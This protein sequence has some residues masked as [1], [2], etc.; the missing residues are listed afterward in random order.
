ARLRLA[1]RSLRSLAGSAQDGPRSATIS[2][3][4]LA[5]GSLRARF[6]RLRAPL[7]TAL[8]PPPSH[9][10]RSPSARC[11]LASLACGLRSGRPS[12]RHHLMVFA[13]LRLAAR[14]LRSLAGSARDGPRSATSSWASLAFG[15]LRAP[16]APLRGPPRAGPPPPPPSVLRAPAPR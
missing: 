15:S 13:R 8:A 7:R 2:W 6:A 4:S 16:F 3:S 10:L 12:L 11:A 1:A 9:G 5:F 14:S